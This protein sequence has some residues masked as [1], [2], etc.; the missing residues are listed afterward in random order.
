MKFDIGYRKDMQKERIHVDKQD[1]G[2]DVKNDSDKVPYPWKDNTFEVIVIQSI[3][4]HLSNPVEILKRIYRIAKDGCMPVRTPHSVSLN[5]S[6]N[7]EHMPSIPP[8]ILK[9][10]DVFPAAG[11]MYYYIYR[12]SPL[13]LWFL[14]TFY[15]NQ[16][17][18]AKIKKEIR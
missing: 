13:G 6:K 11:I 14:P 12:C 2:Q 3:I 5:M 15:W 17:M 18:V 7:P 16:L 10:F 1:F 9:K 8:R 4:E